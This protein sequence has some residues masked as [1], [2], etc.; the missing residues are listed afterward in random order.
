MMNKVVWEWYARD[1]VL[2]VLLNFFENREVVAVFKESFGKRPNTFSYPSEI[3]KEV[4]QGAIAFH[5]SVERWK[6]PMLLKPDMRREEI[7]ELRIG[8]DLVFDPDVQ[9]FEIA[10]IT[11]KVVAEFLKKHRISDFII[12]FSGGKGFHVIVPFETF[13]ESIDFKPISKWYPELL[14]IVIQYFK[15]SMKEKLRDELLALD[16]PFNLAK[17][18][19]KNIT[20][21]LDEE[22]IDPFKIV[23]LDVFGFRHLIRAPYSLHEKTLL[24]SVPVELK[25][26]EKFEREEAKPEL[27][28]VHKFKFEKSNQTEFLFIES[29]DWWAKQEPL[30]ER[31]AKE[32]PKTKKKITKIPKEFFDPCIKRILDG[33]SDGR[34]RAIFVLVTF[35]KNVGYSNK[36]IEEML[37]E[38]N[39]KNNPPLRESYIR[40]QLRWH[41]RQNRNLLPPNHDHPNFYKSMGVLSPECQNYKNP[42]SYTFSKFFTMFPK[43]KKRKKTFNSKL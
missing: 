31:V 3:L 20:D 34:K 22:G 14:E 33:L 26:L 6:N 13:P 2:D 1:E 25:K 41:F 21:I 28:S 5:T 17:R 8:W 35:L 18:V 27:V 15:H 40:T 43:R 32:A 12:K 4:S 38:W 10:K 42:L 11:T 19:N 30:K 37:Y 29:I 36:E 24:V 9:D 39:K 7:E 16:T 23:N